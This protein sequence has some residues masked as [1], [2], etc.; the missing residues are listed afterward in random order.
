MNPYQKA[1]TL[2]ARIVGAVIALV[3]VMG[4][5][6]AV[7]WRATGQHVPDYPAERWVGSVLWA[8]GGLALIFAAKPLG[9]LTGRGLE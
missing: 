4:P 7:V 5:I 1:A 2:I 3:G 6:Y 9:R 8:V